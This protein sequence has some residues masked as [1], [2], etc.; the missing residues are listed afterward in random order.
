MDELFL[1]EGVAD[2]QILQM[3]AMLGEPKVFEK[4]DGFFSVAACNCCAFSVAFGFDGGWRHCDGRK[5][6]FCAA[7]S[8]KKG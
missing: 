8:R 3:R 4:G 7:S 1:F 5:P 2:D 6:V